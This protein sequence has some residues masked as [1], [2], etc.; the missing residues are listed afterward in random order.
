[1]RPGKLTMVPPPHSR[2]RGDC[3]E[4]K[5]RTEVMVPSCPADLNSSVVEPEE[6]GTLILLYSV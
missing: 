2:Y 6:P 5:G 4:E 1:M 3:M